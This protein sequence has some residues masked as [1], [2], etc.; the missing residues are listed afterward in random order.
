M[1]LT[2]SPTEESPEGLGLPPW[3]FFY[4]AGSVVYA[5]RCPPAQIFTGEW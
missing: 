5:S 2:A 4:L 3:A 1:N